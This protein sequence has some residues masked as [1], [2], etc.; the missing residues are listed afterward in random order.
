MSDKILKL[1][2]PQINIK[3]LWYQRFISKIWNTSHLICFFIFYITVQY[4]NLYNTIFCHKSWHNAIQP[5]KVNP[6][7]NLY[8]RKLKKKTWKV[9]FA[10]FVLFLSA[11]IW[12]KTFILLLMIVN[13]LCVNSKDY[14]NNVKILLVNMLLAETDFTKSVFL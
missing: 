11:L 14:A 5:S 1:L 12:N 7:L 6:Y 4:L 8:P 10:P 13:K 2:C 3:M 9:K